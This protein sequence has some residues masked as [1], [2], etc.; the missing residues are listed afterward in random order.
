MITMKT[1]LRDYISKFNTF[2]PE[3]ID[4][5]VEH[6]QLESFRK[7]SIILREGEICTKCYFVISGCVRQF[8]L[9]NGDEKTTAFF[10]EGQAAVLY[11]SY[12]KQSPSTYYLYCLEDSVLVAGTREQEEILHKQYPKLAYLVHT[13]M[14][15]DYVKMQERLALFSNYNPEERYQ[16]LLQTQP[17]LI[18]RVPLHQLASYIG[19]TPES[20]SRIRKRVQEHDKS[21]R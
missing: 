18:R 14:P 7:G 1:L 8:Q 5:I 19:V 21:T 20:F 12:M 10:Q 17:E 4:A 6:T 2:D 9:M 11:S 16:I 3:E 15:E 13:L